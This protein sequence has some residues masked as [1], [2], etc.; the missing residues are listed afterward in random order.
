MS[1]GVEQTKE[2]LFEWSASRTISDRSR[3]LVGH[4]I[5][6]ISCGGSRA[7][8]RLD[9]RQLYVWGD[10]RNGQ[11]GL[12]PD[13]KRTDTPTLSEI[14]SKEIVRQVWCGFAQ[15]AVVT[16]GKTF[17]IWGLD[18]F[19]GPVYDPEPINQLSSEHISEVAFGPS[20]TIVLLGKSSHSTYSL[21]KQISCSSASLS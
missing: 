6:Q 17:Y 15:T 7:A 14:V 1:Q 3:L 9:N 13:T 12:G 8:A 4:H 20:V 19:K 21:T 16:E 5:S 11:L 10:G 2:E 18:C